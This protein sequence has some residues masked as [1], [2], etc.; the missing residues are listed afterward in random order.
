MPRTRVIIA[1]LYLLLLAAVTFQSLA[2][3]PSDKMPDAFALC[4][5][6]GRGI[7]LGNGLEAPSEGAWGYKIEDEHL[8]L[9]KEA[10]FDSVRIPIKWSVRAQREPPYTVETKFFDRVDQ[11]LDEAASH[12]LVAV[13]NVHHYDEMYPE[14]DK[15]FRGSMPSGSRSPSTTAI[16]GERDVRTAQRAQRQA[17]RPR[18]NAADRRAAA[19]RPGEQSHARDH[20]RP[21]PSGTT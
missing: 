17:R 12:N 7:N 3:E 14:P 10:G 18:W 21:G 6:I 1:T 13:I 16:A 4:R 15:H 2:A 9:I 11:V 8:R 5:S 19:H 20:R